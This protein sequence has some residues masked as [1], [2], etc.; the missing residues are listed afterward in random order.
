MT[1]MI[2][3]SHFHMRRLPFRHVRY[4]WLSPLLWRQRVAFLGG[5]LGVGL[6]AVGFAMTA[7]RMQMLFQTMLA[8]YPWLPLLLSPAG[9]ALSVT[10]ARRWFPWAAGSG[11]PQAIAARELDSPAT[12]NALLGLPTAFGKMA[13]T[14]LGLAVGASIG[15]EGPTVQ[16]G[17][18]LMVA[19]GAM[20]GLQRQR[21]GLI[22]AGAAAGVSA[23]FNTPLAGIVF[24]IE[25][26][27]QGFESKT[28]GLVLI[29]VIL[30][31]LSS[32]AIVGNYD[33]FGETSTTLPNAAS[34]M[35]VLVIGIA[36]GLSGGLFSRLMIAAPE[37][38]TW[39]TKGW[40]PRHPVQ[41][42]ACFGL[43]CAVIGLLSSGLTYGTGYIEA[44][45][46][47]LGILPPPWWYS[48]AKLLSTLLSSI[49]GL[50][51]GLFAPSLSV[52]AGLGASLSWVAPAAPAGAV[53]MIGMVAYFTGVVQAPL[54]A[55]V[56]AMEMTGNHALL[57]PLM[58]AAAIAYGVSKLIC[59]QP[60]YHALADRMVKVLSPEKAD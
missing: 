7:D 10:M 60:L 19:A 37:L 4:H 45:A 23:A 35:A 13:L 31:G 54:T 2:D 5:A 38:L 53:A 29:A 46:A 39:L 43:A 24:A 18:A 16:I 47:I 58:T 25:E 52:G 15:R 12:S 28:N 59:P 30:A 32:L 41:M 36:G 6:L 56:I 34:W 49:S 14:L 51:G 1:M 11:I 17:A 48:P 3:L 57:L 22:L 44:K 20:A 9:F 42:A 27:A 50:P 33:Y 40:A 21:R 26:M 8:H 55:F